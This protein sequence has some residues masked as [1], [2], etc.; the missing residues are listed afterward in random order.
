[1]PLSLT[2]KVCLTCCG[3]PDGLSLNKLLL[4]PGRLCSLTDPEGWLATR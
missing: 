2:I 3:Q 1:M 4:T